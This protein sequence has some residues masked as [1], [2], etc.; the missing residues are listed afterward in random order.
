MGKAIDLLKMCED[1][2]PIEEI[3]TNLEVID[4]FIED[5]FSKDCLE[6]FGA[7]NLKIVKSHNGYIL[8]DYST[9]ILYRDNNG[10]LFLN[11]HRYSVTTSKIQGQ[12]RNKLNE[13]NIIVDEIGEIDILKRI[14]AKSMNYK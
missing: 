1:L 8:M 11:N 3:L 10:K 9:P 6:L 14:Y 4:M 7:K 5:N 12:V 2:E 13:F